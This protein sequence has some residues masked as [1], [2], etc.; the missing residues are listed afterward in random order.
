MNSLASDMERLVDFMRNYRR[1]V[2]ITGAGVS[3]ASGIPTYRD[4]TGKWLFSEPIQHGDFLKSSATRQRYWA[5]SLLGWPTIRDAIPNRAHVALAGLE[6]QGRI[7]LLITQN[8]DRLHQRAGSSAVVDLHGRLDRVACLRCAALLERDRVQQ[9]L[10]ANNSSFRSLHAAERPDG[11]SQLADKLSASLQLP[12]CPYCDGDLIP[13]VVFFGGTI[14]CD[15]LAR[16]RENLQ[17]ADGL[18]AIGSSLQVYSGFRFCRFASTMGKPIALINPGKTRA[19]DL[20]MLHV[21]SPCEMV[22]DEAVSELSG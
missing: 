13:D 19:D 6:R 18:I 21:R 8:V 11:D 15:R 1:L 5:R 10:V 2:V 3:L 4:Q 22:L 17:Q 9:Q 7:K 14:P 16:C 12:T 20:A